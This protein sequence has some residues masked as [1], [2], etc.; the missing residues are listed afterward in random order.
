MSGGF[1]FFGC[2]AG[3]AGG[4]ITPA[5]V[6]PTTLVGSWAIDPNA[7]RYLF[8]ANGNPL[9][10]DGTDQRVYFAVCGADTAVPVITPATLNQQIQALRTA[11][12]PLVDDGSISGLGVTATDD[13]AATSLKSVIYTNSGTNRSVTLKVR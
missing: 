8:D 6:T 10:M 3:P 2:G 5:G 9:A 1:G 4:P 13:G 7:Q 11:L 12:K